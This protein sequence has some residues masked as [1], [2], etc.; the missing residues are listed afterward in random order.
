MEFIGEYLKKTRTEKKISINKVASDL[1]ISTYIL[2][3]I[4]NDDF[5]DDLN[6]V[7]LTGHIR[8]YAKFL[9]LDSNLIVNKFKTQTLYSNDIKTIEIP[10]PLDQK[11]FFLHSKTVSLFSFIIIS[12]GFYMFFIR[13]NDLNPNYAITPDLTPDLE[14][15]IEE[16]RLTSDLN[17]LNNE[18]L[19]K[20]Q[21]SLASI[22]TQDNQTP[23]NL[24]IL[25]NQETIS[26]SQIDVV[27][28]M[29]NQDQISSLKN[30]KVTLKFLDST[31]IQIRDSNDK[32]I[33]SKLMNTNEE[34]S[35]FIKD[36]YYITSG[37][38][39]NIVI[40]IDDIGKGKIGKKGEVIESLFINSDFSN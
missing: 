17:D 10:K 19:L 3:K 21:K 15:E 28:S 16:I 33:L 37:N 6:K 11:N 1:N 29:P 25:E 18:N 4:E 8:S 27:A 39:G 9:N 23:E 34:Y 40:F 13:S 7:Y 24:F 22:V 35:Y 5:S 2:N 36:K 12:I 26:T 32:I 20:N 14:A 38:A 30:N 31:W